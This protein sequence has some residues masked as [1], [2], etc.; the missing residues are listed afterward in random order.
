[1]IRRLSI[2]IS[3]TLAA[4][5]VGVGLPAGPAGAGA[6]LLPD[7]DAFYVYDGSTPLSSHAP[8]AVLKKRVI[9]EHYL[10]LPLP[11]KVT[12]V[13]YRTTGTF[14]E[15]TAT[16]ATI[17]PPIIKTFAKPRLV[18]YQ[19]EYDALGQQCTP[20][21]FFSGGFN[22]SGGASAAEQSALFAYLF[23]GYTVVV[24]DYEG[25]DQHFLSPGE[26]GRGTLDGIRAATNSGAYG[27]NSSTP[28]GMVGYSGGSFATGWASELLPSYAA[29]L[30]PR[31]VGAAIGGVPTDFTHNLAYADGT[32]LWPGA[33]PL[34]L[35]GL[36]RSYKFDLNK[37]AS[38]YGKEIFAKVAD[39]CVVDVLGLYP[40]LTFAKLMKPEF[41]TFESIPE[42]AELVDDLRMGQHDVPPMP[43][44]V[45][46]AKFDATGDGIIVTED[47]KELARRYCAAGTPTVYRQYTGLEHVT[48]FALF[49]PDAL[50]WLSGRFNRHAIKSNCST[51]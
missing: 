40:G 2:L 42:L 18:S 50:G 17:V 13:L 46:S 10:G 19:Y 6:P 43:M 26:S 14:G 34:A 8:G 23:N 5:L 4:V 9:T 27:V 37:Y 24:P 3:L 16:V 21:Y 20:S 36:A 29:E 25:T 28:V 30:A 49:I 35:V 44:Y 39:Q 33:I 38:D 32:L 51:L 31:M 45:V 48:G 1:M 11:M 41:P 7:E 15:P 22:L 12:Q 47:V